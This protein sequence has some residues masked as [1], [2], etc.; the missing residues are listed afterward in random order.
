MSTIRQ[1]F[2]TEGSSGSGV[3]IDGL[4][5]KDKVAHTELSWELESTA[6]QALSSGTNNL[7]TFN[8]VNWDT[9]GGVA[10]TSL[11]RAIAPIAGKYWCGFQTRI[12]DASRLFVYRFYVNGSLTKNTYVYTRI[13]NDKTRTYSEVFNLAA[14]DYVQVYI[15]A[16]SASTVAG[17]TSGT[18]KSKFT[19]FFIGE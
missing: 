6:T 11:N 19:G 13:A 18:G 15:F 12:D 5:I 3:T 1:D 7:I 17:A 4:L 2:I 10:S 8:T 9:Y 16:F 14:S